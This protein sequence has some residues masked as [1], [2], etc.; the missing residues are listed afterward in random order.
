M[1]LGAG[2]DWVGVGGTDDQELWLS[3]FYWLYDATT[4]QPSGIHVTAGNDTGTD[5]T[6]M[7]EVACLAP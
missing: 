1:A 4:G 6:V 3:E 2:V 7:V 5:A